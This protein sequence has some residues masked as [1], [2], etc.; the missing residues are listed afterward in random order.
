MFINLLD[1]AVKYT[2]PGDRIRVEAAAMDDE[3]QVVISDTGIGIAEEQLPR[4]RQ[5]FY[6]VDAGAAGAGIG[7][8]MVDEIVRLHGGRVEIDSEPHVGTTVTVVLPRESR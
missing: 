5:K 1:N 3:V 7:L 4:I 6:Q 8:A 2:R